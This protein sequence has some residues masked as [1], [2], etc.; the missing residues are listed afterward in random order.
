MSGV[1]RRHYQATCNPHSQGNAFTCSMLNGKSHQVWKSAKHLSNELSLQR[2]ATHRRKAF[3]FVRV[4]NR[5]RL[6]F[7]WTH[8][9]KNSVPTTQRTQRFSVTTN[10]TVNAV[11]Q[12]DGKLLQISEWKS[13][14]SHPNPQL[15]FWR[16]K[17]FF[18][19]LAHP[20]YKMW[21]IQEQNMLELW[22]KLHFE[23]EKTDS[24]HHV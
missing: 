11:R 16:R 17:Y 18:L 24:I 12:S 10:Q 3:V 21:I 7:I 15:T 5:W 6:K 23:E 14:K 9:F 20:V 4:Q 2:S 22:N 13:A 19:I 1:I 8:A